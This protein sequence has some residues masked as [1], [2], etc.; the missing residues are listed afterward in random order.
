MIQILAKARLESLGL[1]DA[2]CECSNI[3]TG[4]IE[5]EASGNVTIPF[6]PFSVQNNVESGTVAEGSASFEF[7]LPV[8]D[9]KP[10]IARNAAVTEPISVRIL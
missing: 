9:N 7:N 1:D 3:P 2:S 10:E 8:A 5:P 4:Q 6:D